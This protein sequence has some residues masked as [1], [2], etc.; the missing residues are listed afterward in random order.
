MQHCGTMHSGEGL[1]PLLEGCF[2]Q[3]SQVFSG[4]GAFPHRVLPSIA[5]DWVILWFHPLCYFLEMVAIKTI[6]GIQDP[7][8]SWMFPGISTGK[9]DDVFH[10]P[11]LHVLHFPAFQLCFCECDPHSFMWLE[12]STNTPR[13]WM[14]HDVKIFG[15][16]RVYDPPLTNSFPLI[17][18]KMSHS[19][20]LC[21]SW[22]L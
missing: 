4:S 14:E 7:A 3:V 9:L 11:K 5:K 1:Q 17:P 13:E 2:Y 10:T 15:E 18:P 16:I 8:F 21:L 6:R 19:Q 20:L 22:G 12:A